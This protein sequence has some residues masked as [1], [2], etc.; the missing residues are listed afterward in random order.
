MAWS[1]L[2]P[3]LARTL[4]WSH[5]QRKTGAD[6]A[7]LAGNTLGSEGHVVLGS[8]IVHQQLSQRRGTG[9]VHWGIVGDFEDV[10][11]L[12]A[13]C[14]M[15]ETG[16]PFDHA[17]DG[18]DLQATHVV[19]YDGIEPVGTLRIRWFKDFAK[20]E[21]TAF[22]KSHRGMFGRRIGRASDL[23]EQARRGNRVEEITAAARLEA[24]DQVPR[25]VNMRHDVDRPASLP[26]FIRRAAPIHR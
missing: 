4:E 23:R 7:A 12:R 21:R 1:P 2:T 11:A 25:G 22:R 16:L 6:D 19:G 26:R 10:F 20:L 13:I 8:I 14:F 5:R 3:T 9:V 15:E 18:N 24:R 17:F